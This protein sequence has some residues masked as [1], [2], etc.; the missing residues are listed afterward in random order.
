[1]SV[2]NV[3]KINQFGMTK[4]IFFVKG[5]EF[6]DLVEQLDYFNHVY[7]RNG[8]YFVINSDLFTTIK[9]EVNYS[10][11]KLEK[12]P[13][14]ITFIS[15]VFPGK[16]IFEKIIDVF[17]MAKDIEIMCWVWFDSKLHKFFIDFGEQVINPGGIQY[18]INEKY[19]NSDR[20]KLYLEIHSHHTMS[21]HFSLTDDED[22]KQ[23]PHAIY[24]VIGKINVNTGDFEYKFR[25]RNGIDSFMELDIT[26][27]FDIGVED[28]E[29]MKRNDYLDIYKNHLLFK[30]DGESYGSQ[31]K[32]V[33]DLLKKVKSET[34][35]IFEIDKILGGKDKFD[36]DI[37]KTKFGY[38][39]NQHC[40]KSHN[41]VEDKTLKD[42]IRRRLQDECSK[43]VNNPGAEIHGNHNCNICQLCEIFDN[44]CSECPGSSVIVEFL[45]TDLVN[46]IIEDELEKGGKTCNCL[47]S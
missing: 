6:Y 38:S 19:V 33:Y 42:R 32:T 15:K 41:I 17:R 29:D 9:K 4:V 34:K 36:I 5:Q 26:D 8:M 27:V 2:M 13:N 21:A 3:D 10:N 35:D 23:K 14:D 43:L 44:D 18:K 1:M 30:Y 22:E 47:K 11:I 16:E 24:G 31:I 39:G 20:Y 28:I 40:N 37:L 45:G 7:T 25:I 12:I 46:Q